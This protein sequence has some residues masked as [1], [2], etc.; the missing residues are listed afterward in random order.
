MDFRGASAD[1][2]AALETVLDEVVAGGADV[3]RVGDDLFTVARLVRGEPTLR[4]VATDVSVDAR[5]KQGLVQQ[6]FGG[7]IDA[8]AQQVLGEAVARRWTRGRDLPDA[9]E[10]L[11]EL[12]LVRSAGDDAVRLADELFALARLVEDNPD[13]RDALSDPARSADDKA[14]LLDALL[15]GKAL[16][17]TLTLAKQ[18][19]AGTYRTV[20]ASLKAYE[21][22]AA[23]VRDERVAIVRVAKPLSDGDR[24]RL[25]TA[26]TRQY[27]KSVHLNVLVD[28]D[29]IGGVKVEIGQD[30]IDGTVA[31][32]LDDAGRRLAG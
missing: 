6:I 26:L 23:R 27:G 15:G 12:A 19:L 30:V 32:R 11:S 18:S 3:G 16:P 1:S 22:V 10:Y 14:A 17:A 9:L 21:A 25:E 13:L 31:S 24:Q 7:R 8:A 29:V 2:L 4:R 20:A 28:P 5:A